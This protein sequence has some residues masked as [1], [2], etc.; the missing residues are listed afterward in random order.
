MLLK[1]LFAFNMIHALSTALSTAFDMVH[2]ASTAAFF[3]LTLHLQNH[4][5][6]G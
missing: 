1:L 2:A 4:R 5:F 3:I 6:G